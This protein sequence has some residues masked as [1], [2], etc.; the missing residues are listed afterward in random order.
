[1]STAQTLSLEF[2][3]LSCDE[4]INIINETSP[5]ISQDVE[6]E[7]LDLSENSPWWAVN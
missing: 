2:E 3:P 7:G 4:I 1:M 5:L 6:L